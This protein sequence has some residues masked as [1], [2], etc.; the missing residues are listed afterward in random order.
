MVL[1]Q[2]GK[3]FLRYFSRK[4]LL[5]LG[6]LAV[7][8]IFLLAT[9]YRDIPAFQ[10]RW[11]PCLQY[12]G[13]GVLYQGQPRCVQGPIFFGAAFLVWKVFGAGFEMAVLTLGILMHLLIFSLIVFLVRYQKIEVSP[14]FLALLYVLLMFIPSASH[15]DA[16]AA[17]LFFLLGFIALWYVRERNG[18]MLA[19][20]LFGISLLIK[21]VALIPMLVVVCAYLFRAFPF[22]NWREFLREKLFPRVVSL[23]YLT[24]PLFGIILLF[25]FL[26]PGT[27]LYNFVVLGLHEQ[28]SLL[29]GALDFFHFLSSPVQNALITEFS[30]GIIG[31][32]AAIDAAW[33]VVMGGIILGAVFW[34]KVH[35]EIGGVFFLSFLLMSFLNLKFGGGELTRHLLPL[36]PLFIFLS[37]QAF[38]AVRDRNSFHQKLG[39]CCLLLLLITMGFALFHIAPR[40]QVQEFQQLKDEVNDF[41]LQIPWEQYRVLTDTNLTL[42]HSKIAPLAQD[43]LPEPLPL[44]AQIDSTQARRLEHLGA[45]TGN[46]KS[47][48]S[49]GYGKAADIAENLL[50]GEYDAAY[51][52]PVE[53]NSAVAVLITVFQAEL[54]LLNVS[55]YQQSQFAC[56][57]NFLVIQDPCPTCKRQARLI[58][59]DEKLCGQIISELKDYYKIHFEKYCSADYTHGAFLAERVDFL[60]EYACHSRKSVLMR[61]YAHGLIVTYSELILFLILF[62]GVVYYSWWRKHA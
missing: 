57:I 1:S 11:I 12:V 28:G 19:G 27:L 42:L 61:D 53:G 34:W 44:E 14:W 18:L 62:G 31:K 17:T 6:L 38:S 49:L 20:F 22:R 60:S 56:E 50:E 48:R 33:L 30:P 2:Y 51:I 32:L 54:L 58:L 13:E 9:T 45:L 8:M 24:G 55:L 26:F 37:V 5:V 47:W 46:W 36:F 59:K 15:S 21:A 4:D 52:N 41:L 7:A 25:K 40:E 16:L 43:I 35:R 39:Y 10:E 3:R 29:Q 23:F